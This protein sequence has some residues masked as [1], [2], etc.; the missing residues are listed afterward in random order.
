MTL[1]PSFHSE[2]TRNHERE[3]QRVLAKPTRSRRDA[4]E[5]TDAAA[6]ELAG[7][8]QAARSGDSQAWESLLSRFSP[9]LHT[10][11]REYRLQP[12]DVD[13]VV[14]ATWE[15]ALSHIAQLREPEAIAGWLCII[16][17]RQALRVLRSR[18]REL[19]VAELL[20]REEPNSSSAD[21]GLI[22][23]EQQV[24]VRAAVGRL[25]ERQRSLIGELFRDS[26]PGYTDLSTNLRMPQG[27][28]GPTRARALSRLRRD[29]EL[30]AMVMP[31]RRA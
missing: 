9:M 13:D 4:G 1:H 18:R 17:R 5:Q 25:P 10:V 20:E 3:V 27:S 19:P 2:F 31:A 26:N 14:A 24:A 21:E 28:I 15:A 12:A 11:A 23:A 30:V 8:V 29:R 22:R 7:V 6:Y 16:V